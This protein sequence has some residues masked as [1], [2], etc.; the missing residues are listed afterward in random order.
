MTPVKTFENALGEL[1]ELA[2]EIRLKLHLANMD[3]KTTWDETLEPK[4]FQ[5]RQLARDATDASKH[6]V[7]EAVNALRNFSKSL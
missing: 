7:E 2:E 6:S 3:A 5:A 4:L 1:E